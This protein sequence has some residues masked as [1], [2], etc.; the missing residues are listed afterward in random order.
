MLGF[1]VDGCAGQH[2]TAEGFDPRVIHGGAAVTSGAM[3][4]PGGELPSDDGAESFSQA[5]TRE[6]QPPDWSKWHDLA[7][8][9]GYRILSLDQPERIGALIQS[10]EVDAVMGIS[11]LSGLEQA[12]DRV[13]SWGLPCMA[14]PVWSVND[15]GHFV[16]EAWVAG[17][18]Q[19]RHVVAPSRNGH[20]G[21]SSCDRSA[22]ALPTRSASEPGTSDGNLAVAQADSPIEA[23]EGYRLIMQAARQLFELERLE[24]LMPRSNN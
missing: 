22:T 16:D 21:T 8:R 12:M 11:D 19:T 10:G 13:L 4:T 15:C 7:C 3:G 14:E 17:M 23:R 24:Q 18:I 1:D 5:A 2:F 20:G 9:L 6:S